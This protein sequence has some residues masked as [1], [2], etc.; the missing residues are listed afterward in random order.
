[1]K[2]TT[3]IERAGQLRLYWIPRSQ[4]SRG[5]FSTMPIFERLLSLHSS[6]V[7]E[8]DFFTEVVCEFFSRN[9]DIHFMWLERVLGA[10]YP[11]PATALIETR[12]TYPALTR[13]AEWLDGCGGTAASNRAEA[14]WFRASPKGGVH[15]AASARPARRYC[16]PYPSSR[17]R[18]PSARMTT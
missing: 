18:N 13:R 16:T 1:M 7:P 15:C 6:P 8:E 12:K 11:P 14:D 10:T 9:M 2:L 17:P 5:Q 3:P 4:T